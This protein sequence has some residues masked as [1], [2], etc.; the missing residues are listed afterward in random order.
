[1]C[2]CVFI[3]EKKF[4]ISYLWNFNICI[5]NFFINITAHFKHLLSL[6]DNIILDINSNNPG[7]LFFSSSLFFVHSTDAQVLLNKKTLYSF[8]HPI[9]LHFSSLPHSPV[10]LFS[11][12]I[13]QSPYHKNLNLI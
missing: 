8:L 13:Y 5:N 12:P 7:S 9:K 4:L 2:V 11:P 1:M 6:E 3:E 10:A